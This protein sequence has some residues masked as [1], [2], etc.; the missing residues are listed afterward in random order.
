MAATAASMADA[1]AAALGSNSP[2]TLLLTAILIGSALQLIISALT[3]LKNV[4]LRVYLVVQLVGL[5]YILPAS[6]RTELY[7]HVKTQAYLAF[8]S[9]YL[10]RNAFAKMFFA[11][12]NATGECF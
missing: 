4:G 6:A 9:A 3:T 12:N 7:D 11:S 10:T 8:S 1:L 5:W 2:L